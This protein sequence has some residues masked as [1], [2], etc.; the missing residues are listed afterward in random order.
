MNFRSCSRV[1]LP[2]LA[3][4]AFTAC[5]GKSDEATAGSPRAAGQ[6]P[7]YVLGSTLHLRKAPSADAE[8]LEK[9]RIGTEC[10]PLEPVQGE[11]RKVRCGDKE[12]Y[13]SASLLGT[14]K[15][16]VEKLR[17]EARDPKRPLAQREDA[18]LRAA[19]LEPG[20]AELSQE[21]GDLFFERN[22]E[23]L[24]GVKNP[25]KGPEL[26]Y[27]CLADEELTDC[28][29]SSAGPIRNVKRRAVTKGKAFVLAIG[30]AE[31]VAVYRGRFRFDKEDKVLKEVVQ[32]RTSFTSTP[33]MDQALFPDLEADDTEDD[34]T[35][36]RLGQFVLDG[37]SQSLLGALPREWW[38]LLPSDDGAHRVRRNEC[39]TERYYSLELSPDVHG[40]WI[41]GIVNPGVPLREERWISAVSK[42]KSGTTLTLM[43]SAE[44]PAPQVFEIPADGSHLAHLG[45]EL[46]TSSGSNYGYHNEPCGSVEPAGPSFSG[47]FQP[48]K[49]MVA[50]YGRFDAES[51]TAR[52]FPTV[53]ERGDLATL[54]NFMAGHYRA[55]P[56]KWASWREGEQEKM[57]FLTET[58]SGHVCHACPALI[59]GGI[60]SRT[61]EGWRLERARRVILELGAYGEAP[62]DDISVQGVSPRGF[63]AVL[64]DSYGN[65]GVL[66]TF[67]ALISDGGQETLQV[68]G[69]IPDIHKDNSGTCDSGEGKGGDEESPSL[70]A[71]YSYESEWKFVP[72][73]DRPF[74]D[75]VVTTKGSRMGR[76]EGQGV[77]D[78]HEVRT[79]S[80]DGRTYSLVSR[81]P[82][83]EQAAAHP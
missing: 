22:F 48:E 83:R 55:R 61:E 13:A 47:E 59:G 58:S 16:S 18:A 54:E 72:H 53:S 67:L 39:S 4:L 28:I 10:A 76:G 11:W 3:S 9:L 25:L 38:L 6:P 19:T 21:L 12:G 8:S 62:D 32:E 27:P 7:L 36:P 34:S 56:W 82:V 42:T 73:E 70:P 35:S 80:F 24:A 63:V 74:P 37:T 66:E 23:L 49:A 40:R 78:F 5:K 31:Q 43:G 15:P 2:L 68:A 14:E 69:A 77:E 57:L 51:G 41:A 44:D 79:F 75:F 60:F 52:W 46:Y 64:T 26:A 81:V 1:L 17:A 71:C 30:D 50:L 29:A 65:Q 45:E 33:V 20:N